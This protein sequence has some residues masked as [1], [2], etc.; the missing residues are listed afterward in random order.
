ML[1][2][3]SVY[4]PSDW[5]TITKRHNSDTKWRRVKVR[6]GIFWRHLAEAD[7]VLLRTLLNY[8]TIKAILLLFFSHAIRLHIYRVSCVRCAHVLVNLFINWGKRMSRKWLKCESKDRH[9][10]SA[11]HSKA[12]QSNPFNRNSK[13]CFS[14][15]HSFVGSSIKCDVIER[16]RCFVLRQLH[17]KLTLPNAKIF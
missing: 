15:L 9:E 7:D 3:L 1:L 14:V 12:K 11:M 10:S 8:K 6:F 17:G 16:R 4:S 2:L 13:M 5:L